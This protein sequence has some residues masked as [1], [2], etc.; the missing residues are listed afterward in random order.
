MANA[1]R[2]END[3]PG[4]LAAD[5][6]T[7]ATFPVQGVSST[8]R[9][10]VDAGTI[11]IGAVSGNK[12]N[13]AAVPGTTNLGVLG[14]VANASAPTYTET[15][16]VALSTDLSGNLRTILNAET[17]KVIG[18]VNQG[19]SP[20]VISGAVTNTVLSVVGG[21][22]EATAQRVTLASDSTGVITVKQATA[23]NLNA[24]VVGT[25]T[26][27]VQATPVTQADTFMLGGINI[28]EINAVTPL[29]GNGGTG[30]GSLRVTVASDNTAF[31]VNATL[32]AETTKVIG[33]VRML[34]NI[35]AIVDG[36][37]TAATAPANGVLGL[38]IYNST[39]PSPT[40]GQ[41][42]GIQLDS[43]GRTRQVIM[44]AAGNTRGV[45]VN[46]S[47]QMSVS[48]DNTVTVGTHAVTVAS[49]GIA[50]G[51]LA[52]GS[53]ASGA[54]ASGSIASGAI[55]AGAVAAGASSFVKLEDV[56]SAD[57][58]AGVPAMA[59][60]KATPT[61]TAGTDGDY[62]MLQMKNGKLWTQASGSVATN[63]AIADNPLNNGAQAVSSENTA[64]TALRQ[65][66]LV[67]DLVGKLIV[68]PY[69]NPENFVSGVI[70]SAMTG[71]TSTSL[72]AAPA[73]GLRNYITQITVSNGSTTVPTDILIQ[74]GSGGTTL[75]V[76]P[77][78]IGTGTGT[79]T[80]GGTFTFPTPLRQP[81]TATAIFVA[82][83][84]T[85]SSTKVSVTGYK[86]A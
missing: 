12:T 58:D 69:A 37:N 29:M 67:A 24:T 31:S 70:T 75:Y 9:L 32:S 23:G 38:G 81:T 80:S 4:L 59:I 39:E 15:Y 83:V 56:A 52:S 44:D 11:T 2:D 22:T 10:L 82:N 1:P 49:G 85:G 61:D 18:T 20:W 21:G 72:M 55:V 5:N 19:T 42:V 47:N 54:F 40:T 43:K 8:G 34:G 27:A 14:A 48:V 84:T 13:N 77:A 51:A 53:V 62:Q 26:F 45:N 46:A 63:V 28:K 57:A 86:G 79:G 66:Q 6:I 3:V 74:D 68:L 64:V 30:T 78:P 71:T 76:I 25:G 33:T 41:S 16:Q 36:V 60:L 73:A 50:S 35:G 17:T 7:G 65:V